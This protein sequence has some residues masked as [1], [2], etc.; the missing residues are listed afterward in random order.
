M[1][2]INKLNQDILNLTMQI[3]RLIGARDYAHDLLKQLETSECEQ[4]D[5]KKA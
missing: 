5:Q 4:K 3:E 1:D 2:L